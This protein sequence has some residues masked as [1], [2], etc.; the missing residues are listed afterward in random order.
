MARTRTLLELRTE[1]RQRADLEGAT[2][3]I[4]DTEVDRYINQSIAD[5]YDILRDHAPEDYYSE[6]LTYSVSATFITPPTRFFQLLSLERVDG[7]R[8][9]RLQ[10]I[11]AR[12]RPLL[13]GAGG[14]P[15][16][17]RMVGQVSDTT[18]VFTPSI[19]L[20]PNSSTVYQFTLRYLPHAPVLNSDTD[21]WDG[22]NGWEEYAVLDAALKCME[23]EQNPD[24]GP[25]VARL[26]RVRDRIV[27]LSAHWDEGENT[28]VRDVYEFEPDPY[29]A[30]R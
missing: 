7:T 24:T 23:K 1:V 30:H 11:D 19:E 3:F 29:W 5:L 8:V 2:A 17:Y 18:G 21:V 22:F 25:L 15:T 20:Y 10:R 26:A 6:S 13:V 12:D 14:P 9:V 27:S 16:H 4:P 28:K